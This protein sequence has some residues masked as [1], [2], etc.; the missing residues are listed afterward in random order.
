[1]SARGSEVKL[2]ERCAALIKEL[3]TRCPGVLPEEPLPAGKPAK[4]VAVGAKE[5]EQLVSLAARQNAAIAALGRLPASDE[6]LPGVVIWEQ[7]ASA[8]AVLVGQIGVET[9][10]GAITVTVPVFCDQLEGGKGA[11]VVTFVVGAPDRPTG[12][13]AATLRTPEGP[14]AVVEVWGDQITALAWQAVLDTAA[15][16]AGKS[17]VDTDG[18]PL[19]A[20]ALVAAAS[21][22]QVLPQ[23][24]HGFDRV[25]P[26]RAVT[27]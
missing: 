8:L 4:P 26:F 2:D 12:L 6:E 16:I 15:G 7:G 5:Y 19:V 23:A 27:S 11:V 10:P 20:T 17:G 14:P 18:T 22:I 1:M 9:E 3:R 13:L 25:P 24:R 21:G